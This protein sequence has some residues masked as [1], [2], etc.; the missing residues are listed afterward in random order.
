MTTFD[1]KMSKLSIKVL[2]VTNTTTI[3][4]VMN[5]QGLMTQQWQ[6]HYIMFLIVFW[7]PMNW[8]AD[9]NDLVKLTESH[10]EMNIIP[11]IIF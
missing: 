11:A 2:M 8:F 3:R 5:L 1:C 10:A 9:L 4:A 7:Y 6:W